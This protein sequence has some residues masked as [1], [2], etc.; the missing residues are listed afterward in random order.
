M[1]ERSSASGGKDDGY[2]AV[3]P[4]LKRCA[5]RFADLIESEPTPLRA[6]E[7]IGRPLGSESFLDA[8]AS[9]TGRDARPAKRGPKN[10]GI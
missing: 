3:A 6:A 9:L 5:G 10:R 7:T 2:V 8:V 1:A 4:I